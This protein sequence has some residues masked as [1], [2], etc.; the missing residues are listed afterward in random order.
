MPEIGKWTAK[1]PILFA[2]GDSNLYGYVQNDPVNFI[3]PLGLKTDWHK[4]YKY[5][6][7]VTGPIKS[8]LQ[9][10]IDKADSFVRTQILKKLN[11][12]TPTAK[13]VLGLT[14]GLGGTLV[15]GELMN[16]REVADSTLIGATPVPVNWDTNN[17]G[18]P[19]HLE[20]D[21]DSC[22]Q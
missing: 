4:F 9:K 2:G 21:E 13:N 12:P 18:I 15:I 5:T 19:D 6:S 3:D 7:T 10:G 22:K 11:I 20:K 14:R 8:T 1:D 17:N 16:A